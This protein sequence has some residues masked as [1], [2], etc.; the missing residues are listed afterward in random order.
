M[1]GEPVSIAVHGA[2]GRM[3]RAVLRLAADEG[4]ARVRAAL[5]GAGSKQLGK[6]CPGHAGLTF[7]SALADTARPQVLV[8]F[9]TAAAFDAALQLARTHRIGFV[10]GTTGLG[11]AQ[12]AALD[13]AARHI[14]VL[15]EANFSLGIAVLSRLVA[16]AARLLPEWDCEI[17][18]AHHGGKRDAPSGTALA[19]GREVTAARGQDFDAAACLA[20]AGISDSGRQPGSIGFAAVRAA[21]IVG[22]HSVLLATAGE[23]IELAHRASDR[24]LFARGALFAAGALAGAAPGR[25][26][27]EELLDV[28]PR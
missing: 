14:P 26:R 8:D 23:R 18:E 22:E 19:L 27:L 5:V 12:L 17:I 21:D 24:D 3:G 16:E 9:S 11:A 2:S 20:R 7:G 28:G 15:W 6:P 13:E 4:T 25:Y 1:A 10:S